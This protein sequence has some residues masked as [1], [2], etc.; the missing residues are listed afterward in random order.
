[1]IFPKTCIFCAKIRKTVKKNEQ[2]F[3][4]AERKSFDINIEKYGNWL[5]DDFKDASLSSQI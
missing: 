5:V 3:V 4:Q 2:R 1:M